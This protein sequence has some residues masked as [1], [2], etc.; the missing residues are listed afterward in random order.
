MSFRLIG[1]DVKMTVYQD[2]NLLV[3]YFVHRVHDFVT[4]TSLHIV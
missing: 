2:V 1:E 4:V 3:S